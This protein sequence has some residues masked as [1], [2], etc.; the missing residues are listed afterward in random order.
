MFVTNYINEKYYFTFESY[1][2]NV[3]KAR[4]ARKLLSDKTDILLLFGPINEKVK[5]KL[6]SGHK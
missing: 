3:V 6:K 2:T 4:T 5:N 1:I